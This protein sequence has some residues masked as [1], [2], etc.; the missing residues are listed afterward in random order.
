MGRPRR[1]CPFWVRWNMKALLVL[2]VLAT[3]ACIACGGD[4]ADTVPVVKGT[5]APLEAE[6]IDW[7]AHVMAVLPASVADSGVWHSNPALA[8]P[9]AGVQSARTGE[10][11]ESWTRGQQ[12]AY[13]YA[14]SGVRTNAMYYSMWQSYPDWDETFGFGAWDTGAMAETGANPEKDAKTNVLLGTFNV[15]VLLGR[16]DTAWVNSKLLDFGYEKR[17]HLGVEYLALPEDVRSKSGWLSQL[18]LDTDMRNVLVGE[19][20]LITAPSEER[21]EEVLSARA[22]ET[23]N[24]LDHAAFG[25]LASLAPDPLFAAILD[26]QAV[27]GR[28]ELSQSMGLEVPLERPEGRGDVGNWEALSAVYSRPSSDVTRVAFSLWYADF[29][30]AEV[31]AAELKRRFSRQALSASG[32]SHLLINC[33]AWQVATLD[34]PNGAV[35]EIACQVEGSEHASGLVAM[36]HGELN[37]GGFGFMIE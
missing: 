35:V 18:T 3:L 26:R 25:D 30:E 34:T 37:Q 23:P 14:T 19:R 2:L 21:M 15:Q 5:P 22:G 20:S 4:S 1:A 16:F 6:K 10:E 17:N 24:L 27:R 7:L 32:D 29:A 13:H 12:E 33:A 8:L 36:M 9:L 11:W 31:G 28:E